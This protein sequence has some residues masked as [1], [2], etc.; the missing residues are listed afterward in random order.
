[1]AG[2]KVRPGGVL[3]AR[4]DLIVQIAARQR[5]LRTGVVVRPHELLARIELVL[6]VVR[7]RLVPGTF[8]AGQSASSFTAFGS[9]ASG[10]T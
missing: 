6:I 2:R 8:G 1:M 10:G 3:A 4:V 7:Y 9:R 5:P